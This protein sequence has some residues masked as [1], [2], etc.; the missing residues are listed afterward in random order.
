MMVPEFYSLCSGRF[1][2]GVA[3]GMYSVVVPK[4][5]NETAPI[6]LKGSYGAITQFY[7]TFG[8][9][10]AFLMALPVPSGTAG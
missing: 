1:L 2:F 7:V 6:E 8:I 9:M 10:I 3:A 4:F 5:I